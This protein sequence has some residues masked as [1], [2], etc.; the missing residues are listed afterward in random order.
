M[1]RYRTSKDPILDITE[2]FA[3]HGRG[4]ATRGNAP[5]PP[6]RPPVILEQ[7]LVTQ[8]YLMLLLMKNESCCGADRS[9]PRQQ[10]QD[11]L[12]SDF[13]AT[14]MPIF[15]Q[16][17]PSSGYSNVR[18][19]RKLCTQ[20]NSSEAQLQP[21]GPSTPPRYPRIIMFHGASS[22]PPSVVIIYQQVC[23]AAS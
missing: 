1:V 14:H 9:Q 2:G 8:N 13:L 21:S 10:D 4:Q 3:R 15:A 5:P 11:S 19:F 18:S 17:S 7:L 22:A 6:P 23:S 20:Q 12:Y 16:R